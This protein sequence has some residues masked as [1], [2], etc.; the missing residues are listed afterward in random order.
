MIKIIFDFWLDFSVS[1]HNQLKKYESEPEL[2]IILNTSFVQSLNINTILVLVLKLINFNLI[3]IRY[4]L[5]VVIIIF[6]LNYLAYNR[7]SEER[8]ELIKKRVPKHNRLF[9]LTY[10]LLSALLLFVV[11]YLVSPNSR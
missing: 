11:V 5:I 9:Y 6:I 4:L 8:K 10:S 1:R 7:M 2:R 3:E